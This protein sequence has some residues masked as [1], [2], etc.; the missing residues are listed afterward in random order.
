MLAGDLEA[1]WKYLVG[2]EGEELKAAKTWFQRTHA[3]LSEKMYWDQRTA[4]GTD[5]DALDIRQRAMWMLALGPVALL[6]PATA[7]QKIP[8]RAMQSWRAEP[9]PEFLVDRL[10]EADRDWVI[11]FVEAA[12]SADLGD[13]GGV[14]AS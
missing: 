1:A 7:A 13:G 8:W 4:A 9:G 5:D 6:G 12:S 14:M 3:N 2:L 10:R 11:A